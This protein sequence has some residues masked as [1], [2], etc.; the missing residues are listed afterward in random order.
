MGIPAYVP[1]S[2]ILARQF[3]VTAIISLARTL[4]TSVGLYDQGLHLAKADSALRHV[5]E[6]SDTTIA[7][8][9]PAYAIHRTTHYTAVYPGLNS[10]CGAGGPPQRE[11]P[12]YCRV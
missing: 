11:S 7:H 8:P 10:S 1:I 5:L 2:R 12:V 6:S 9:K 3:T 4:K